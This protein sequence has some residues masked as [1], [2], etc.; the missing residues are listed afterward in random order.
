MCNKYECPEAFRRIFLNVFN[1]NYR[2]FADVLTMI[3]SG[4]E[5]DVNDFDEDIHYIERVYV[6]CRSLHHRNLCD[7][8]SSV[9]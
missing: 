2:N 5:K 7:I 6:R 8:L 1:P 3:N 4:M 9:C